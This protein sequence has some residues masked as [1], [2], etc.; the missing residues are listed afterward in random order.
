VRSVRGEFGTDISSATAAGSRISLSMARQRCTSQ[1]WALP[2]RTR[3]EN[4][5]GG[6]GERMIRSPTET[7]HH[8]AEELTRLMIPRDFSTATLAVPVRL[9]GRQRWV[10]AVRPAPKILAITRRRQMRPRGVILQSRPEA[11]RL[12]QTSTVHYWAGRDSG[13]CL[14]LGNQ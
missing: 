7:K 6:D 9:V 1:S 14:H 13:Q 4:D 10:R 5:V 12:D 11:V 3:R 8:I 2:H